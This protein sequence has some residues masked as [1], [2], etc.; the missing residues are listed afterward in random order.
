MSKFTELSEKIKKAI[1]F[2][3]QKNEES[4]E[5]NQSVED[6]QDDKTQPS[7]NASGDVENESSDEINSDPSKEEKKE[8]TPEDQKRKKIIMIVVVLAMAVFLFGPEE[9]EQSPLEQNK[10]AKKPPSKKNTN[11]KVVK[12]KKNKEIENV[13]KNSPVKEK[14]NEQVEMDYSEFEIPSDDIKDD[15]DIA[16]QNKAPEKLS[17]LTNY[18]DN[19]EEDEVIE[20]E[21]NEIYPDETPFEELPGLQ[22]LNT[23][24][25]SQTDEISEDENQGISDL[26]EKINESFKKKQTIEIDYESLGRGLAYNCQDG[27]WVCLNKKEYLNCRESLKWANR[28]G[29]ERS[30]VPQEVYASVEDCQIMQIHNINISAPSKFCN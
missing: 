20:K 16:D 12:K 1:P 4:I 17:D 23:D 25:L 22:D 14:N 21:N 28:L 26:N 18:A 15:S 9:E 24:S 6:V 30:C 7:F 8:L 27:H 29:N 10:V 19:A 11:I 5:V 3:N 13:R 2:L